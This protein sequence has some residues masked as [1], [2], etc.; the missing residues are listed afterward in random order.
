MLARLSGDRHEVIT[1]VCLQGPR[2][3]TTASAVTRV[4]FRA[5]AP[6]EIAHY[7]Q[8]Y[9]PFD[10]AGAY[11]IQEWIGLVAIERIDGS[12]S[13]VVGLPTHLVDRMLREYLTRS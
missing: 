12:Y 8:A 1:G 13:N 3:H 4:E 9:A 2:G 10:K 7:V 11:G 6:D 5:L